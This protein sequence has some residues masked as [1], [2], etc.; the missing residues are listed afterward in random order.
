MEA[1]EW[2]EHTNEAP[3]LCRS[4]GMEAAVPSQE[5]SPEADVSQSTSRDDLKTAPEVLMGSRLFPL[6]GW[7]KKKQKIGLLLARGKKAET[8]EGSVRFKTSHP[9]KESDARCRRCL[10][11]PPPSTY[12]T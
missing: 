9:G 2:G 12:S 5:D 8:R 7:W 3:A 4:H 10:T 11:Q 1:E 6:L